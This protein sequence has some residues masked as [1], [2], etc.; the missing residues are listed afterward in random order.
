MHEFGHFIV[1]KKSGIRVLEFALGMGPAIFKRKG[2]ET[3]FTVRLL[4]IGGYCKMEGEDDES[5]DPQA[6]CNKPVWKRI[7]VVAAGALM[8]LVI[9][10]VI[11]FALVLS[12]SKLPSVTVAEFY[13]TSVSD[14]YGLEVGDE[15]IKI[16]GKVV[17]IYTDISGAF[18]R[19]YGKESV[20]ITVLRDGEK[21]FLDDV[22][23]PLMQ[24]SED[25]SSI[26]PDFYVM[27][28]A[29]TVGSVLKHTF[30]RTVSYV[31]MMYESLFDMI[32]G[33]VS[34]RYVSGPIGTSQVIAEA[35]ASGLASLASLMAL[36]SI[37]L[38][39]INLLPLPALD[40]GRLVFLV[41]EGIRKKPINRDAEAI[42]HFVGLILLLILMV[43]VAFKD[44]FFPIY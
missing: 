3:L 8:N 31:T 40:G 5:D 35:A 39:V 43:V 14:G 11:T 33:R 20:D 1:A 21:V 44:I 18:S 29:K 23:F 2:K 28:E 6:F 17:N 34:L 9:A 32:T 10:L 30:F 12:E 22:Q 4:P 13:D 15:I 41:I 27:A 19:T 38:C 37:N 25:M 7:L 16:D 26:V 24:I 42:I 36:I